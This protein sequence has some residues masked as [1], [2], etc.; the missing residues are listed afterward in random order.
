MIVNFVGAQVKAPIF[1]RVLLN[2]EPTEIETLKLFGRSVE[3]GV[4][5]I[6]GDHASADHCAGCHRAPE[7]VGTG[8][9]P[10]G[11]QAGDHRHEDAGA[12]SPERNLGDYPR[13]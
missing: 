5:Y 9:V 11:Q 4:D 10:D 6:E 1:R 2:R 7:H 8:K 12:R 3:D 13:V